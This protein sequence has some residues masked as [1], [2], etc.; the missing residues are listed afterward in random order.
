MQC[1]FYSI[2]GHF[3]TPSEDKVD[4]VKDKNQTTHVSISLIWQGHIIIVYG[5]NVLILDKDVDVI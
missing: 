5:Y 1:K 2:P 3:D 4:K